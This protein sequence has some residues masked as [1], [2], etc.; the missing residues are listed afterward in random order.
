MERSTEAAPFPFQRLKSEV[1]LVILFQG[2]PEGYLVRKDSGANFALAVVK[3]K[4]EEP[5][6]KT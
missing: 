5:T 6:A 2:I 3:I 1:R 4:K